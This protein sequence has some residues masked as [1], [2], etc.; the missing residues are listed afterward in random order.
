MNRNMQKE[1]RKEKLLKTVRKN[2]R[3]NK[4]TGPHYKKQFLKQLCPYYK[5]PLSM[6]ELINYL[7]KEHLNSFE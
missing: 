7:K 6:D 4:K 5:F 3:E 1:G 2:F